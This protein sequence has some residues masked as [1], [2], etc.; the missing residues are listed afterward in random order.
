MYFLYYLGTPAYLQNMNLKVY[1]NS[2]ANQ[3]WKTFGFHRT[4]YTM[5]DLGR[6]GTPYRELLLII[7]LCY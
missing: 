5:I 7:F 1:K 3:V 4:T 6:L 2:I